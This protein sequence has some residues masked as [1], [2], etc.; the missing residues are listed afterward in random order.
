MPQIIRVLGAI[1]NIFKKLASKIRARKARRDAEKGKREG[2]WYNNAHEKKKSA[3]NAPVE[4]EYFDGA[5]FDM[6]ETN[7]IAK[8]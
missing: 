7:K 6:A 3:W 1:M 8:R 2:C 5:W 4:G